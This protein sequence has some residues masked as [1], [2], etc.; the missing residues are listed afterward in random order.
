M[1]LLRTF[2][3]SVKCQLA[4]RQLLPPSICARRAITEPSPSG[5]KNS[6]AIQPVVMNSQAILTYTD[7]IH[8][9]RVLLPHLSLYEELC[10]IPA[11]ILPCKPIYFILSLHR[12]SMIP[13]AL[14][15]L[16]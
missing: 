6:S 11:L 9:T 7:M 15:A 13:V 12:L 16:C 3:E 1:V 14:M 4:S 10:P 2:Q 5:G 8:S